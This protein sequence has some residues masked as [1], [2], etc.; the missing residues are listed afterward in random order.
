MLAEIFRCLWRYVGG[1]LLGFLFVLGCASV[2]SGKI[3]LALIYFSLMVALQAGA[4]RIHWM[5]R[6]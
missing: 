1:L 6:R 3:P 4:E 2:G 5:L